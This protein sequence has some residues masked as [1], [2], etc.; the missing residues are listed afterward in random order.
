MELCGRDQP[1]E[2]QPQCVSRANENFRGRNRPHKNNPAAALTII[3]EAICCQSMVARY[4]HFPIAQ[5]NILIL[6]KDNSL[7]S[8]PSPTCG[9]HESISLTP[10]FS[11]VSDASERPSTAVAV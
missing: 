7:R 9:C 10:R 1:I 3:K 11:E 2:E 5:E 4:P 6:E 8:A